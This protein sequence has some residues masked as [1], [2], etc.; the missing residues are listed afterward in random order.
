MVVNI[1]NNSYRLIKF[2]DD[3]KEILNEYACRMFTFCDLRYYLLLDPLVANAMEEHQAE[4]ALTGT[5]SDT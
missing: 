5:G 2:E 4:Y 1:K 3:V